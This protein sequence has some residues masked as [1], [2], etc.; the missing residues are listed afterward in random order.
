MRTLCICI[1]VIWPFSLI[2]FRWPT[3]FQTTVFAARLYVFQVQCVS[4]STYPLWHKAAC[5]YCRVDRLYAVLDHS[6]QHPPG[7]VQHWCIL[8]IYRLE[9]KQVHVIK[10]VLTRPL[11]VGWF[12]QLLLQ[13]QKNSSL[14]YRHSWSPLIQTCLFPFPHYFQL[15]TISIGFILQSFNIGYFKLFIVSTESL[16]KW[17]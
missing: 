5:L 9:I 14:E 8:D 13:H 4:T 7:Q 6:S 15:K 10:N 12:C 16:R 3:T 17:G 2:H 11:V 1:Y